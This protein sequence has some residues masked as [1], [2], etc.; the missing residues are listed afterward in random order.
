MPGYEADG[1]GTTPGTTVG[2]AIKTPGRASQA[3]CFGL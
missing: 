2:Y 3:Y 1:C